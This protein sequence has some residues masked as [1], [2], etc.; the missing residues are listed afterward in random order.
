MGAPFKI[1][2]AER[3]SMTQPQLEHALQESGCPVV[4][5][6]DM[7]MK[8]V[9]KP[10]AF[11]ENASAN[12]ILGIVNTL[13]GSGRKYCAVFTLNNTRCSIFAEDV[14]PSA[15]DRKREENRTEGHAPRVTR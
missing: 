11:R 7:G 9:T 3:G 4:S 13:A 2:R 14:T 1:C 15:D 6:P 8:A 12:G 10:L 5:V